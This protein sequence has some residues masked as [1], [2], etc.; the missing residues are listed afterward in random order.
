MSP[1]RAALVAI[2]AT[3]A[4]AGPA[5][6]TCID[7][8]EIRFVDASCQTVKTIT[9]GEE[10]RMVIK[11]KVCCYAGSAES[12]SCTEG[13]S[14]SRDS[15]AMRV[16]GTTLDGSFIYSEDKCDGEAVMRFDGTLRPGKVHDVARGRMNYESIKV[17]DDWEELGGCSA[18]S[19]APDFSWPL[20]IVIVLAGRRR[21][22]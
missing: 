2:L 9:R 4:L 21:R 15:W 1:S 10:L 5:H 18:A 20:L 14:M 12:E 6:A 19:G 13:E 11:Q 16:D 3:V 17:A 8:V 7:V 22:R